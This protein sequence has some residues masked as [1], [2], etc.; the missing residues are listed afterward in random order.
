MSRKKCSFICV[1]R[2]WKYW[3]LEGSIECYR[4]VFDGKVIVY[5]IILSDESRT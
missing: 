5:V 2:F 1:V 4:K 3:I